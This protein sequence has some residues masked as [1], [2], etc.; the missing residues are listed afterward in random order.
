MV[1]LRFYKSPGLLAGQFNEKLNAIREKSDSVVGLETEIV[2]YMECHAALTEKEID[3]VKSVLT[4]RFEPENLKN[5]SGL[6]K[7]EGN[8]RESSIIV[9]IGPRLIRKKFLALRLRIYRLTRVIQIIENLIL[10]WGIFVLVENGPGIFLVVARVS[11][12]YIFWCSDLSVILFFVQ[13]ICFWKLWFKFVFNIPESL[14]SN[15]R[16]FFA[17]NEILFQRVKFGLKIWGKFNGISFYTGSTFQQH[18]PAMLYR[19]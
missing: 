18:S 10:G 2:Y 6:E 16:S 11:C 13:K 17:V 4:S 19:Y 8:N 7:T 12:F 1:I 9:E 14:K 15:P 3:V 5:F